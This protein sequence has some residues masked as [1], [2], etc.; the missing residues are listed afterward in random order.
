MGLFDLPAPVLNFLDQYLAGI[1]SPF[2]RIALWGAIGAWL[3]MLIYKQIS[4]Q[5]SLIQIKRKLKS[6]QTQLYDF[7]GEF[8]QLWPLIFQNLG[9]SFKRLGK[10]LFPAIVSG[11]PLL[12]ILVWCSNQFAYEIP[13]PLKPVQIELEAKAGALNQ[14]QWLPHQQSKPH[15]DSLSWEIPWPD[16]DHLVRLQT[17]DQKI[18]SLPLSA[19]VTIIH[20]K[21]WW[22]WLIGNPAGYLVPDSPV[23]IIRINLTQQQIIPFGPSWVRSWWFSFFSML[24]LVS[25]I[26]KIRWSLQ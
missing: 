12:C 18:F 8:K 23:K 11:M 20:E 16:Q 17:Q 6:V 7:E 3:S 15:T 1:F 22:N 26:F 10:T 2:C 25:M 24:L 9:L 14:V 19:P 4:N 5:Q 21:R 13:P